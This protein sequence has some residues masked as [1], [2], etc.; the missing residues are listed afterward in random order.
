MTVQKDNVSVVELV[1]AFSIGKM[2]FPELLDALQQREGLDEAEYKAGMDTLW[3]MREEQAIDQV[4]I[5]TLLDRLQVMRAH[6]AMP[7][8]QDVD[9]VLL[10][11]Q[12]ICT[13]F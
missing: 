3:R 4:S 12:G 11:L 9:V 5:T 10:C 8:D 7:V 6:Q 2:D 1:T 13:S